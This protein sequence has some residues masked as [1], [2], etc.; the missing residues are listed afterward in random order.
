MNARRM[1][2][3]G[4]MWV[5]MAAMTRVGFAQSDPDYTPEDI[6]ADQQHAVARLSIVS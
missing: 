6:A 5:A 2:C 4:L 1:I 3:A